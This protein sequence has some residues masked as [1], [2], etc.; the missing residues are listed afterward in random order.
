MKLHGKYILGNEYE[1]LDAFMI[2]FLRNLVAGYTIDG[3][4]YFNFNDLY[5]FCYN[6]YLYFE[7]IVT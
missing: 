1:S 6:V 7:C 2:F 5:G 3:Y 4:I